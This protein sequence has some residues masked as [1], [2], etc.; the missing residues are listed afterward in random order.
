LVEW[1]LE[2]GVSKPGVE[3]KTTAPK[4]TTPPR[5]TTETATNYDFD[6]S[7]ETAL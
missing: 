5:E 7:P 6:L 2:G 3:G 1:L 4:P